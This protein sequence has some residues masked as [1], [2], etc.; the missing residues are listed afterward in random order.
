MTLALYEHIHMRNSFFATALTI[1]VAVLT[2][3]C[4]QSVS[5][6]TAVSAPPSA[7]YT[8]AQL[9][10]T[11]LLASIQPTGNAKQDRPFGSTYTIS[12]T[13]G[14]LSARVDCNACAGSFSV[15]G[16]TLTAGPNLACTRAACPTMSF[17]NT[18][19]SM[20]SGDSETAVTNSTLTL[21]SS[22]GTLWLVRQ[23]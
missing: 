20:L 2:A 22:R 11:W 10:G 15:S 14:R 23:D 12:F 7:A 19:T 16:T 4:T 9:E 1:G 21:T 13:N 8:V 17:E 6:P 3:A 5:S 18:F